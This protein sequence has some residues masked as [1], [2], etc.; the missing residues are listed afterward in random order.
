MTTSRH[1]ADWMNETLDRLAREVAA[2]IPATAALAVVGIHT[3][4]SVLAQRLAERLRAAG[5]EVAVGHVDVTLYRDDIND[6]GG[7]KA[8][9]ASDLAFNV[10]EKTI[11]L[12]DDVLGTGRTIR[13]AMTEI[14]DFGRP[15][16]IQ[17][18]AFIDRG[19]RELPIEPEF[20]GA[21]MTVPAERSVQVRVAE[22]DG[23]DE[24]AVE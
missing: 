17:L 5:R 20:V 21:R 10:N 2:A 15:A 16:R 4:G 19:G 3:R 13:A 12:V 14:M 6:G 1:D 7:R 23:T 24:V 22:V 9:H 18:L 11:L 8:I